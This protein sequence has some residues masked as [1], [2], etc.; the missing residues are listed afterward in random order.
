[1]PMVFENP[2]KKYIFACYMYFNPGVKLSWNMP[3]QQRLLFIW[4]AYNFIKAKA[5]WFWGQNGVTC[6]KSDN[7]GMMVAHY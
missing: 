1:M 5:F 2:F 7:Q 3:Y 6:Y 4:A